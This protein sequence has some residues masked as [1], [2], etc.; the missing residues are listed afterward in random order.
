MNSSGTTDV[1]A[2]GLVAIRAMTMD[3][4]AWLACCALFNTSCTVPNWN[5]WVSKMSME[6]STTAS[7]VGYMNPIF[8]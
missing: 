6:Q 1:V 3:E 7:I 2:E 8:H 4:L 5:G